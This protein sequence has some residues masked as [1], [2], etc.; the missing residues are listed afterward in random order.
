MK[1]SSKQIRY[2]R[3]LAHHRSPAVTLGAQGLTPAVLAEI[4]G[5]LVHHE[6]LKIKLSSGDKSAR[7]Q[8]LER[9]C[10]VTQA[11]AV[12]EI[13]RMAVVFKPGVKSSIALP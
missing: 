8:M 13:G 6:L 2:L 5:A 3:G 7:H 12:Q 4:D 10:E 1:L 9:I 11:T